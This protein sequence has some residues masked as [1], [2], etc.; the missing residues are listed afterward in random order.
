MDEAALQSSGSSLCPIIYSE[1][2]ENTID[3]AFDGCFTDIQSLSDCFI[4]VAGYD[5]FKHFDLSPS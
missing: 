1:L 4:A 2:A 3:V 5:L